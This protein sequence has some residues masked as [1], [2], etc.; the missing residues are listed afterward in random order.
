MDVSIATPLQSGPSQRAV[1]LATAPFWPE[2]VPSATIGR[3]TSFA[4]DTVGAA[5]GMATAVAAVAA[6]AKR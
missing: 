6:T 5:G 2:P 3:S 4:I 1:A